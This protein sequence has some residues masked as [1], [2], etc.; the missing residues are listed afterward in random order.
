MRGPRFPSG[1]VAVGRPYEGV[2]VRLLDE[3]GREVGTDEVGEITVRSRHLALGYWR[4]EALTRERFLPDPA[5]GAERICRTGD[6]GQLRPDGLLVH[7]GRKDFQVK[8][9]GN[10]VE[11]GEV[12]EALRPCPGSTTRR[13]PPAR[14]RTERI[15]SSATW[16]GRGSPVPRRSFRAGLARRCPAHMVP[17]AF[18]SL[19][20]LPLTARGKV[21]RAALKPPGRRALRPK[22][23]VA[24]PETTIEKALVAIWEELLRVRPVGVGTTS[25]SWAGIPSSPSSCSP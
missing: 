16:C 22:A 17:A 1:P 4:Q 13:S 5:G 25:S 6:L 24:G 11:V 21:D 18:V 12:E 2:E 14:A 20:A 10:R 19:P 7:L 23:S 8:I 9:R 15:V 3:N